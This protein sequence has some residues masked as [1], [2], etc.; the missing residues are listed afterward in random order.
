MSEPPS[1]SRRRWFRRT[2]GPLLVTAFLFH[3]A[4]HYLLPVQTSTVTMFALL[5]LFVALPTPSAAQECQATPFAC[6]VDQSIELGLQNLR[7]RERGTGEFSEDLPNHNALGILAFLERRSG[8]GWL[9]PAQGYDGLDVA[10]QEMVLVA[11]EGT[12]LDLL[13]RAELDQLLASGWG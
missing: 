13:R 2:R 11:V 8:V 12:E 6:A 3:T 1:P 7:N 4:A 10:D 9:G 5:L